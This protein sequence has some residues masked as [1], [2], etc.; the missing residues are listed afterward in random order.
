MKAREIVNVLRDH[1]HK[2][3]R[4]INNETGSEYQIDAIAE[5]QCEGVIY[6]IINND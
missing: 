5:D 6:L 2:E 4:I 1:K 3:V